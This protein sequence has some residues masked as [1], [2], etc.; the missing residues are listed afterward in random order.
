MRPDRAF[1]S[2]D[3][4]LGYP[5]RPHIHLL[6]AAAALTACAAPTP[7]PRRHG[8]LVGDGDAVF[9][10]GNSFF[11]WQARSLPTWV[12][13]IGEAATPPLRLEVGG[14]IV[15]GDLPLADFL[16]HEATQA[17]LASRRYDVFVLQ[18]HEFEPVDHKA[19][20]HRSVREL[21]AAIRAAG[22]RSVLF[23]T[24]GFHFRPFVDELAA[25][26]EEIA[27]ELDIPVIPAGLVH[28]D[29]TRDPPPG[30]SGH[31]LTADDNHPDG[32]LHQNAF[33]TAANAFTTFAVLTGRDP[34]GLTP[35]MA[36]DEI[37]AATLAYLAERAHAR[38]SVRL[39]PVH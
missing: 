4:P 26:Y 17:A 5:M 8:P 37:D 12:A 23:M 16:G 33:G 35:P 24:W 18:G 20:F 21:D 30:R 9:F 19:E 34:R 15:P 39:Q 7:E 6:T 36:A 25:S 31:W 29:C 13:G 3:R 1:G 32:D 22:G 28:D 2:T 11:E 27:G 38:A 14:D 10:V